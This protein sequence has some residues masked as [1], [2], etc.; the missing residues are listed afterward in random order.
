MEIDGDVEFGEETVSYDLI[1]R[2]FHSTLNT[3]T[4][5]ASE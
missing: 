5:V 4:L 2:V 1:C 3:G